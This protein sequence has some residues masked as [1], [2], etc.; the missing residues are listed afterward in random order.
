MTTDVASPAAQDIPPRTTTV[1]QGRLDSFSS[2]GNATTTSGNTAG[3][4]PAP[5]TP[6]P[7]TTELPTQPGGGRTFV[8]KPHHDP[9]PALEVLCRTI[10]DHARQWTYVSADDLRNAA[11]ATPNKTARFGNAFRVLVQRGDL[12]YSHHK[13][14]KNPSNHGRQIQ[15]FRLAKLPH[16]VKVCP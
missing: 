13:P 9:A 14:S 12:L 6:N 2:P 3:S 15:V 16:R 11:P 1:H 5:G 10:M 4:S 7:H 8:T